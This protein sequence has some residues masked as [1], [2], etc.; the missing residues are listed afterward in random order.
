M[1]WFRV[2]HRKHKFEGGVEMEMSTIQLLLFADDLMLVTERD[3]DVVRNIKVLDEV[4]TK[5][6]IKITAYILNHML[7][8]Y[9]FRF[10]HSW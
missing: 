10:A 6:R 4:M 9:S 8:V 1:D 2:G 7:F 3:E 5:W